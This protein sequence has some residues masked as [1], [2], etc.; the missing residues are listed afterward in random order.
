MRIVI[1]GNSGSGKSTLARELAAHRY[2][3]ALD[4][5]TVAWERGK[6]AAPRN[7]R[8]AISDIHAFCSSTEHWVIEGCYASL[9]EAALEWSP[10]LI[11]LDPGLQTCL[12]NCRQRPWEPHKYASKQEQDM[13]LELLLAW[14]REYYRR[15][16]DHSLI[17]H[18][19]VFDRYQGTKQRF[20]EHVDPQSI[21]SPVSPAH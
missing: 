3:T 11:F 7:P 17:A 1:L 21:E 10:S 14:V 15:D 6:I 9:A 4:L 2:L 8:D 18:Q 5:D 16:G 19:A 20:T 13:K 12:E